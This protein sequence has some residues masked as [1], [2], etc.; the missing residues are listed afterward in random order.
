MRFNDDDFYEF[1]PGTKKIVAR[2][3]AK[4]ARGEELHRKLSNSLGYVGLKSHPSPYREGHRVAKGAGLNAA[5]PGDDHH[6]LK[7]GYIA[8]ISTELKRS[9][10]KKAMKQ[11]SDAYGASKDTDDENKKSALQKIMQKRG[12]GI[13]RIM[14]TSKVME[15][16]ELDE[17]SIG[18][19]MKLRDLHNHLKDKGWELSRTTGGHD[20][21][22][23]PKA[24]EHIAVPRHKKVSPGVM[25]DVIKK[26]SKLIG[27][28]SM[29]KFGAFVAEGFSDEKEAA[30]DLV[31]MHGKNI[32]GSH[33]SAYEKD[34]DMDARKEMDRGALRK[35][36]EKL[37]GKL[38]EAVAAGH[39][40][41][42]HNELHVSDAGSG[43]YKV[44][45]VG[46]K[47]SSGI[48]VGE[49]LTDTHLDD[50]A[51]MGGK[52]K[53][54]KKA[55]K[56]DIS[57]GKFPSKTPS[58]NELHKTLGPTKNRSQ[59]VQALMKTHNMSRT[60]AKKHISRL[61]SIL[62]KEEVEQVDE[63]SR[64]TLGSY[65][66]KAS[67][68]R[69]HRNMSTK[70]VDKRYAGVAKAS[71]RLDNQLEEVEQ[72]DELRTSTMLRY[73]T[74]ASQ[75]LVGGDRSKEE[76][77][78]KG[79][80]TAIS[81]IKKRHTKEEVEPINEL[82]KDK[83]KMY[84]DKAKAM[85]KNARAY[86][87]FNADPD[88]PDLADK[89]WK[90]HEKLEKGIKRAKEKMSEDVEQVDELKKSTLG[91]YVNKAAT[92]VGTSRSIATDF[93]N[94]SKEHTDPMYKKASSNLA[95]QFHD[96][97]DKRQKGI[98]KATSKL[99]KD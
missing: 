1:H 76:K 37:G 43:K 56:E 67:D 39:P 66:A 92:A 59:G 27:E 6:G 26:S 46:K 83:L 42:K 33:V 80:E 44:H 45:A 24:K 2:H 30:K 98:A 8:E 78:F 51:E 52:V 97:A 85:S 96:T 72:V 89:N 34:S 20:V 13:G 60:K 21:Y 18:A 50:F 32:K 82:S 87:S 17:G 23:H 16:N 40:P 90:K 58:D 77:R 47:F 4:S 62:A 31:K 94:R 95:R 11:Y 12:K 88:D 70:K 84:V 3:G 74:K 10:G 79:I 75:S 99:T 9:Y 63:L 25:G 41:V 86:G 73:S 14:Q 69:G 28:E 19:N 65:V 29:K 7:E 61:M 93:E 36:I 55:M 53:M 68:A 57:E 49:H 48:K 15:S 22:K 91:S 54:M 81:K 71:K 64:K 38:A 5:K 35:H